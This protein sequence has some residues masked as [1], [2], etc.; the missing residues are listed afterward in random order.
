MAWKNF[1]FSFV[2][3]LIDQFAKFCSFVAQRCHIRSNSRHRCFQH[4]VC[5]RKMIQ[6]LLLQ[7]LVST[8]RAISRIRNEEQAR[9]S[10]NNS[11]YIL[12]LQNIFSWGSIFLKLKQLRWTAAAL[13]HSIY[14]RGL[15]KKSNWNAFIDGGFQPKT[16][17][18]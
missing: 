4:V 10:N 6:Q 12:L 9:A 3:Y 8:I 1:Q 2:K 11:P 15:I 17:F 16:S 13:V 5:R 14:I 18:E 7:G